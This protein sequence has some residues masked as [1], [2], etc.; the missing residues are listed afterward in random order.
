MRRVNSSLLVALVVTLQVSPAILEAEVGGAT[1]PGA[2]VRGQLVRA[3]FYEL[4]GR[5]LD[6]T[7]STTGIDGK[8]HLNYQ[9]ANQT[10]DF[11]GD[12][13]EHTKTD[14]GEVVSVFLKT[15]REGG[16]TIFSLIVPRVN[17]APNGT[18]TVRTH[19]LTTRQKI[20]VPPPRGQETNTTVILLTGIATEV[21]F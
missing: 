15:G 18:A 5:D 16:S 10:V 19:G 11:S 14:F 1:R 8:D 12:D 3:N 2:E 6:V 17:I 20:L 9:D 4:S 13:I 7:Y 21:R